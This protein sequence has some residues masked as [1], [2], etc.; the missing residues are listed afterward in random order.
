MSVYSPIISFAIRLIL[1][2]DLG[3]SL[4]GA[5]PRL[6]EIPSKRCD[7]QHPSAIGDHLSILFRSSGMKAPAAF[8]STEMLK[9]ADRKPFFVLHRIAAGRKDDADGSLVSELQLNLIQ[10][11]IN[12]GL[13]DIDNIVLHPREN[14]LRL[15]VA[16]SARPS[17]A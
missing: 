11:P 15:R 6:F 16:P 3:D 17:S 7:P 5:L 9:S 12:A 4:V 13:K 14:D 1:K 10:P 8:L 2:A